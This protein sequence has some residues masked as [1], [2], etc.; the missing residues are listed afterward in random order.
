MWISDN[1][2]FLKLDQKWL[3]YGCKKL[4]NY[5]NIPPLEKNG[6]LVLGHISS[7][8]RTI[9]KKCINISC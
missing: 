3:S 1:F 4:Q 2:K 7:H 8:T 5:G 9:S 6:P